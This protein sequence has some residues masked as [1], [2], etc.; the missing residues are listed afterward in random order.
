MKKF[1]IVT[2]IIVGCFLSIT[3]AN[4]QENITTHDISLGL[5]EV[6]LLATTS[7]GINLSLSAAAVAGEAV[8]QSL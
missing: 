7:T 8:E 3:K 4:A 5:P 6:A 2:G 1:I